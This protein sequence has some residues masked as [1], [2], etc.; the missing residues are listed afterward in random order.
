MLVQESIVDKFQSLLK[1]QTENL[2][3]RPENGS[4]LRGLFTAAS[5]QRVER[6]VNDAKSSGASILSG[7][8]DRSHNLFQPLVLTGV[9]PEMSM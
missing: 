5:A 7:N 4:S 1:Q 6:L 9:T 3:A 2:A 8:Q